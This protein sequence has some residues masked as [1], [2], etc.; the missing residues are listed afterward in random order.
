[1]MYEQFLKMVE[2]KG[3]TL[4]EGQFDPIESGVLSML[5][6]FDTDTLEGRVENITTMLKTL[7]KVREDYDISYE[8]LSELITRMHDYLINF[9]KGDEQ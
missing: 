8:Q 4:D 6:N 1:M 5:L 2:R 9:G 7:D 3:V